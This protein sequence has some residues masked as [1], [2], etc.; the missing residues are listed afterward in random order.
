MPK[1]GVERGELE[2]VA[3]ADE[4]YRHMV[5]EIKA[6]GACAARCGGPGNW[7]WKKPTPATIR[8]PRARA[9][10]S[11]GNRNCRRRVSLD[12]AGI[13]A[14]LETGDGVIDRRFGVLDGVVVDRQEVGTA[15]AGEE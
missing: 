12:F 4:A 10:R 1:F 15:Q 11:A 9:K 6:H 3:G 8:V 5:V 14:A 7:S 2:D 13:H